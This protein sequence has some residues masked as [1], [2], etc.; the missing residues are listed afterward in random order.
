MPGWGLKIEHL[1]RKKHIRDQFHCGE[2]SLDEYIKRFAGQDQKRGLSVAYVLADKDEHVVG[3]YTLSNYSIYIGNCPDDL[4]KGLPNRQHLPAVLIGK[5]A[6]HQKYQ[7]HRW[8][9]KLLMNALSRS[10]KHSASIAAFAVCVYAQNDQAKKFYRKYD[11]RE[12]MDDPFHLFLPLHIIKKLSN[13]IQ[14]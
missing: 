7:G 6:I 9:E 13:T 12:L 5:F 1:Q 2:P 8:G 11:F 10:C 3:F 14:G 4:K